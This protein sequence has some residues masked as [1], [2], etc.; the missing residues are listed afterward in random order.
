M[1]VN[2]Q[3]QVKEATLISMTRKMMHCCL[4]L[5]MTVLMRLT[6]T[7]WKDLD[8]YVKRREIF[9]GISR[10][11]DSTTD[12]NNTTHI[13]EQMFDKCVAHKTVDEINF[14]TQQFKNSRAS[15]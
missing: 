11:Q 13:L 15:P 8:R 7:V 9:N 3:A 14:Y 5:E 4:P 6:Q 12:L 1:T 2:C 10:P